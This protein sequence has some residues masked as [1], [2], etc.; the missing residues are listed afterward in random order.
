MF[1]EGERERQLSLLLTVM[2]MLTGGMTGQHEQRFDHVRDVF[3]SSENKKLRKENKQKV[4]ERETVKTEVEI[5][6]IE[7]LSHSI[8][9]INTIIKRNVMAGY[10][11]AIT[12]GTLKFILV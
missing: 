3:R 11:I 10:D 5:V 12:A 8:K 2:G 1:L 6:R 7:K 4:K 9:V